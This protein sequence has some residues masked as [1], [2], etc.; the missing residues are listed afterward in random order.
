MVAALSLLSL[1]RNLAAFGGL[2]EESSGRFIQKA[3][4]TRLDIASWVTGGSAVITTL[5]V[6]SMIEHKRRR[7]R[8]TESPWFPAV[9]LSLSLLPS[10]YLALVLV[11]RV[12][13]FGVSTFDMGVF[14]QMFHSMRRT[15]MPLTT[16]ERD[17]LMS[18]FKVHLS[19][20]YYA[21]LPVFAIFP[22]AET[23]QVLQVLVVVSGIL[24]LWLLAKKFLPDSKSK[25]VFILSIYLLQPAMLGSSLY[26][27]HENCFLAPLLLW[28]LYFGCERKGPGMLVFTLFTLMVKEDAGLYVITIALYLMISGA[29]TRDEEGGKRDRNRAVAMI[30]VSL[31]HF[32]GSVIFLSRL[33]DG[34]MVDRF[35]NL[36]IY[37]S[38]GYGGIALSVLQNPGYYLATMWTP[39]KLNYMLAVLSSLGFLPIFQKRVGNLVL[40]IP[41]VVMNLLSN[42]GYQYQLAFQYHYGS[43]V[44]LIFLVLLAL[45][46]SGPGL[47]TA[48][49]CPP[50]LK[51]AVSQPY[52]RALACAVAFA[53]AMGISQSY[54]LLKDRRYYVKNLKTNK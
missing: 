9:A 14:T 34:A 36:I 30:L 35:K 21:M 39:D 20:I 1:H 25:R 54:Y 49:N 12:K 53:V 50:R 4:M 37:S 51:P 40:F 10:F 15:G 6:Y 47:W 29:N 22:K 16:L 41:F 45:G 23:L 7:L 33:G 24:P 27:L 46:E 38:M 2:I 11:A 17:A 42:Y 18:H 19:P 48:P 26:D 44:L 43:G 5:M 13:S 31:I 32:S 52:N 3:M 8:L 28:L